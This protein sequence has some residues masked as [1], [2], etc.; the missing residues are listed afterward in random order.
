MERSKNERAVGFG[1]RVRSGDTLVLCIH[2]QSRSRSNRGRWIAKSA[3]QFII[4]KMNR[5]H[6]TRRHTEAHTQIN[7]KLCFAIS[8]PSHNSPPNVCCIVCIA[9]SRTCQPWYG[10]L[11]MNGPRLKDHTWHG[12]HAMSS[13]SNQVLQRPRNHETTKPPC[14][15][16]KSIMTF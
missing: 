8:S 12:P 13:R 15:I 1:Y 11:F 9:Y 6:G 5:P 3:Y 2:S 16:Y 4:D 10:W 7:K 14:R